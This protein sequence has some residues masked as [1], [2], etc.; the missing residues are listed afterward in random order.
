MTKASTRFLFAAVLVFL[1]VSVSTAQNSPLALDNIVQAHRAGVIPPLSVEMIGNVERNGKSE[2]FRIVATRDEELRIDYGAEGKDSLVLSQKLNFR[3]DGK[4]V[5][6][7]KARSGFSQLDVTGLFLIQQ[8]RNR[9]VRV[10]AGDGGIP[11]G[12]VPTHRIR[13]QGERSEQ[14]KGTVRVDDRVDIYVTQAGIL[15]GVARSFYEGRP[16]RY[17]QPGKLRV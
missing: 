7:Q 16:D 14:H 12:G 3:D 4:K 9:A 8:L 13:V 1:L 17:T 11:I 2:A 10:E 15:A 6:Y 5:T